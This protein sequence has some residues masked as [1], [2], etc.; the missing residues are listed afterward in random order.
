MS[1]VFAKES[2]NSALDKSKEQALLIGAKEL[3]QINISDKLDRDF[4]YTVHTRDNIDEGIQYLTQSN[5]NLLVIDI[6]AIDKDGIERIYRIQSHLQVP[7]L[8]IGSDA[9]FLNTLRVDMDTDFISF[10]PKTILNS[11]FKETIN[12]LHKKTGTSQKII[13][14]FTEVSSLNKPLTFY[15]LAGALLLEPIIK[16]LYLK[17]QTGFEWDVLARTILSIEGLENNFEFWALFPLAGYALLSVGSYSFIFFM[18]LQVY[19]LYAYFSYEQFT[20]PYVAESPMISV[21]FLVAVN[22]ALVLYFLVPA[23]RRPYWNQMR[24][25]WRSTARYGTNLKSYLNFENKKVS[26]TIT[27][28]SETGAY[29]TTTKNLSIGQKMQL[30]IPMNGSVQSVEAIVRRAQDTAHEKFVGYGVEFNHKSR[31]EKKDLK[32]FVNSLNQRIQ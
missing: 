9:G 30:E 31:S 16:V 28:I 24:K 14:R 11:M 13:H 26:T 7:C 27:N 23:N 5:I 3:I 8:F 21:S 4:N 17:L 15:I 2:N 10:L 19:S 18:M 25:I 6:D 22:T 1:A 32:N 20:W 12:L 29:F